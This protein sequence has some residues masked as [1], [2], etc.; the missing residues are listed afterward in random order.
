MREDKGPTCRISRTSAFTK[1]RPV[2]GDAVF[3]MQMRR[4]ESE[5]MSKLENLGER[6]RIKEEDEGERGR[7][8]PRLS[9]AASRGR[10]ARGASS[11]LLSG[12]KPGLETV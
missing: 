1:P 2:L 6:W 3:R 4:R 7:G 12:F 5:G 9:R 8:K 11:S 10:P